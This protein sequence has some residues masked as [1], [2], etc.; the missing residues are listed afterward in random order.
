MTS[1]SVVVHHTDELLAAAA[2]AR[3]VTRLVDIQSAGRTPSLVLTGGTIANKMYAALAEMP[4]LHAVDWSRVQLW[5]GDERFVAPGDS[6]RNEVQARATL[7]DQLR[8]DPALVHPMPPDDGVWAGDPE[9]AAADYAGLLAAAAQPEDHGPVPSFDI[10]LLGV[11]PDGHVASLFPERPEL[12]EERPTAAVRHSPKPPPTRVTM[13]MPTLRRARE[14]WFVV[15]GADKA[16][17]VRLAL[18]GAGMMQV[19]AAG[20]VGTSRTLWLLDHD[21]AA[22]LPQSLARLASP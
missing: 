8:L 22:E 11:G 5:W 17:P 1:P 3:L 21:A 20:V 18:G 9:R 6:D 4:A 14:V 10:L 16:K 13:T 15:S 19:P 12:Y 2:A 7:L